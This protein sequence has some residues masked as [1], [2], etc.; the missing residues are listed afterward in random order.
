VS[1]TICQPGCEGLL[2]WGERKAGLKTENG[3][4]EA[5]RF[6]VWAQTPKSVWEEYAADGIGIHEAI[7]TEMSYL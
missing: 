5:T 1:G 7:R 6:H 2:S 4:R 3:D